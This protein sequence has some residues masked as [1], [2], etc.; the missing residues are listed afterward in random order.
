MY[1]ITNHASI[2]TVAQARLIRFARPFPARFIHPLIKN[3]S[4]MC[5]RKG[6]GAE[7]SLVQDLLRCDL[8]NYQMPPDS[9]SEHANLFFQGDHSFRPP[10]I[11]WAVPICLWPLAVRIY[12]YARTDYAIVVHAN[13]TYNAL[14]IRVKNPQ[15][16]I[17]PTPL[18]RVLSVPCFSQSNKP[19]MYSTW[20]SGNELCY[21]DLTGSPFYLM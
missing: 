17:L 15:Y 11:I 4:G 12:I 6:S 7:S 3:S 13:N 1:I 20:Y 8:N 9:I 2:L 18:L 19:G 14:S 16:K 10:F 5:I 21:S